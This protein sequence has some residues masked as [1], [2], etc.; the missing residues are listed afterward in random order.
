MRYARE[1]DSQWSDGYF[2]L[3]EAALLG[4]ASSKSREPVV[5]LAP[6]YS[7]FALDAS[8]V[9]QG[10]PCWVAYTATTKCAQRCVSL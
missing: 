4:Y 1:G 10:L 5:V 2:V 8:Y 3:T 6:K 7:V 9:K